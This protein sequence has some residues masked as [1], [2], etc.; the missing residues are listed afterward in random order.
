[1][2]GGEAVD[3]ELVNTLKLARDLKRSDIPVG[4]IHALM[5]MSVSEVGMMKSLMVNEMQYSQVKAAEQGFLDK[6]SLSDSETS[7]VNK[8]NIKINID[9]QRREDDFLYGR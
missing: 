4:E 6:P 8:E 3:D 2:S 7:V 9:R 1:V 5:N